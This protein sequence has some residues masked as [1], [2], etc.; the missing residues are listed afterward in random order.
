MAYPPGNKFAWNGIVARPLMPAS[1]ETVNGEPFSVPA[2]VKVLQIHMPALVGT[3][4]TAKIQALKPS[5]TV[6]AT[7]VWTDVKVTDLAL[8]TFVAL[9]GIVESTCITMPVSATGGGMLRFVGSEDQSSLPVN[10]VVFMSR[11]G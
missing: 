8:A 10:I 11:D 1:G 2:G 6:E 4:A 3:G 7:Q 5:E 9:P